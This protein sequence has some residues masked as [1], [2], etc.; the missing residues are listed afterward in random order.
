VARSLRAEL[1]QAGSQYGVPKFRVSLV[2]NPAVDVGTIL[3]EGEHR[4]VAIAAFLAETR[5]L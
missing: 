4:C 5:H 1:V 3:S 2:A